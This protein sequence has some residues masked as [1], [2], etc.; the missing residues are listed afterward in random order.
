MAKVMTNT[1]AIEVIK[2]EPKPTVKSELA[3]QVKPADPP[4]A[5]E[6][7]KEQPKEAAKEPEVKADVKESDEG[8]EAEDFDL[9]E[10][11]R[12][13]IGKKHRAMKEAQEAAADA[14][15]FAKNQYDRARLAEERAAQLERELSEVKRVQAPKA[16]ELKQPEKG[17]AKYQV[18]GQFDWD[19][20]TN[21]VAEFKAKKAVQELEAK[22]IEEAQKAAQEKDAAERAEA[23]KKF[24]EKADKI[25]GFQEKLAGS[26]A[27]V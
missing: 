8:L 7:P 15:S 10:I 4:E 19:A 21:D 16:P 1:G 5:R 25:E 11:V 9:S 14:E 6:A 13:K 17:D 27:H 12:K 3:P 22:R 2:A 24:R 26:E 23:A 18:D 20:Y